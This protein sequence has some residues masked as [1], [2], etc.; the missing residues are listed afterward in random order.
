MFNQHKGSANKSPDKSSPTVNVKQREIS[1]SNRTR[2]A[3]NT[4]DLEREESGHIQKRVYTERRLLK[5]LERECNF[6][7]IPVF[8]LILICHR[9]KFQRNASDDW[10][11]YKLEKKIAIRGVVLTLS[12]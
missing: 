10:Y 3:I 9:I 11:T 4:S 12:D 5:K 8:L 2:A 1:A 6:D 7:A